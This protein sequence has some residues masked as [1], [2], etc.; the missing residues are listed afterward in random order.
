[1]TEHP[2]NPPCEEGPSGTISACDHTVPN[3]S[4]SQTEDSKKVFRNFSILM[5][6]NILEK[7][8][9]FFATVSVARYL[10]PAAY[11]IVS[12][13]QAYSQTFSEAIGSFDVTFQRLLFSETKKGE[14]L[15]SGLFVKVLFVFLN[16]LLMMGIMIYFHY[17]RQIQVLVFILLPGVLFQGI[18]GLLL[19]VTQMISR[20]E[21][22]A[23]L[24]F[25]NTFLTLTGILL[26]IYFKGNLFWL[27][28]VSLVPNFLVLVIQAVIAFRIITPQF[29]IGADEIRKILKLCTGN[30][31]LIMMGGIYSRFDIFFM[32]KLGLNELLGY[33]SL[34][35]KPMGQII[36]FCCLFNV[37]YFPL[38]AKSDSRTDLPEPERK[39]IFTG[40]MQDNYFLSMSFAGIFCLLFFF[41]PSPILTFFYGGQYGLSAPFCMGHSIITALVITNIF[42]DNVII[43]LCRLPKLLFVSLFGLILCLGCG[44]WAI[45][46]FGPWGAL[47]V[48]F[49]TEA[50]VI[51][52]KLYLLRDYLPFCRRGMG[53]MGRFL[54]FF[55]GN[56]GIFLCLSRL[57]IPAPMAI[58]LAVGVYLFSLARLFPRVKFE[59]KFPFISLTS[60]SATHV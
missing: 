42:L 24:Y 14:L 51:L 27:V 10:T 22:M 34:A 7:I 23:M 25:L 39:E 5:V 57:P 53:E 52:L 54:L 46:A 2:Q 41:F 35:L 58:A 60:G 19:Q 32:S 59:K 29:H 44:W 8:L 28:G 47:G 4:P 18:L 36:S 3:T 9:Q 37:T 48:K 16:M 15:F 12:T 6:F 20:M 55:G 13:V 43:V 30:W 26:V 17:P 1:M 11:G 50:W 49:L 38:L 21:V 33:Y 45:P 40:L 31:L 56:A